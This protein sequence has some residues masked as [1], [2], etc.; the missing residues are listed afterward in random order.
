MAQKQLR[1]SWSAI[2]SFL[3]CQRKYDLTYN[4]NLQR[5]PSAAHRNL[6][7]GSAFHAG[8]E[9]ALLDTF[10]GEY[11]QMVG[12][13]E[14]C[15]SRAVA[16][17]K[18]YI[19]QSTV[20][21]KEIK[22]WENGGVKVRDDQYY[23]MLLDTE[24]VVTALLRFHIPLIGLGTRYTV[25][26][27]ADVLSG[28]PP[29]YR[30]TDGTPIPAIEWHF[31]YQLDPD[32]VISGYID[33]IV[34]DNE[35]GEYVMIDWK[36]RGTFPDDAMAMIDGQLHLYAAIVNDMALQHSGVTPIN[37]VLMYQMKTKTPSPAS[38][39]AKNGTPNTGAASYDTTWEHWK[40]TLP[41][42]IN[43][44]RYYEV[45]KNK[46]K[47]PTDFQR[48][49]DAAA[50]EVSGMMALDNIRAAVSSIRSALDS[51]KPMAAILSSDKCK[52]CDFMMLCGNVLRYGGDA[53]TLL[54]EF[55]Q[56]RDGNEID[57]TMA[58]ED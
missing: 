2:Q 3:S 5:K 20:K 22:D 45:M 48:L 10:E 30:G 26:T 11:H 8:L 46:V 33:S 27:V 39:H 19:A 4:E 51:G 1:L 17:A 49:V 58:A 41:K 12:T 29:E 38:I 6:I 44:D 36:T 47:Q 37:K 9:E 31:E 28:Q 15:V 42:G 40:A 21:N 7:L 52:W 16:A 23:A 55:Y 32:T 53:S 57:E 25:P 24:V 13:Q 34:W 50:T 43:P 56:T 35:V 18:R 14:W 54:S